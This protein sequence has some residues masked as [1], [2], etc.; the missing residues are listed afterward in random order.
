[1]N[2][3]CQADC[4]LGAPI[5]VLSRDLLNSNHGLWRTELH[6]DLGL[7]EKYFM[8]QSLSLAWNAG[9]ETLGKGERSEVREKETMESGMMARSI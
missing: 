5:S 8:Q 7:V 1:M 9:L 4:L 2:A 3:A 6:P